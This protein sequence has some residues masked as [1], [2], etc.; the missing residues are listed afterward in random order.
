[1]DWDDGFFHK[2]GTVPFF[3]DSLKSSMSVFLAAGPRCLIMSFGTPSD[4]GAFL[5]FHCF[6]ATSISFMVIGWLMWCFFLHAKQR[7][8][9]GASVW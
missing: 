3:Y 4:P 6:I 1:M 9:V 5:Q 2:V 7:V 8:S